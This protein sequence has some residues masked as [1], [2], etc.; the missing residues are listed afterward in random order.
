MLGRIFAGVRRLFSNSASSYPVSDDLLFALLG[1]RQNNT[2]SGVY[3]NPESALTYPPV[4]QAVD[5]LSTAVAKTSLHLNRVLPQGGKQREVKHWA[6]KLVSRKPSFDLTAF[7][8]KRCMVISALQNGNAYSYIRREGAAVVELVPL[9]STRVRPTREYGKGLQYVVK[10]KQPDGSDKEQTYSPADIFHIRDL[11]Y[12]DGSCGRSRVKVC[13]EAIAHGIAMQLFGGK[14]FGSGLHPSGL[15]S[16]E[17]KVPNIEEFRQS[18]EQ[19]HAGMTNAH[20]LMILDQ[21]AKF[22]P[23]STNPE[24][25]QFIE[26]QKF[27]RS[28]VGSIFN[29]P[30]SRLNDTA[31]RTWASLDQDDLFFLQNSLEPWFVSFETEAWDKLLTEQDKDNGVLSFEFNRA[32][33]LKTD[34]RTQYETLYRAT[35]GPVL[36]P[37]EGRT[38]LNLPAVE[39]GDTLRVPS[40]TEPINKPPEEPQNNDV[41]PA[42]KQTV[43]RYMAES[44]H[45]EVAA[46][47]KLTGKPKGFCDGVADYYGQF[48]K[49]LLAA[50]TPAVEGYEAVSHGFL[51]LI[52]AVRDYVAE[53]QRRIGAIADSASY[54]ELAAAVEQETTDWP[55]RAEQFVN[56]LFRE[57]VLAKAA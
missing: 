43:A 49:H 37:N 57:S 30:A 16:V 56:E 39:G 40:N 24:Q 22:T 3:V 27:V 12:Y 13:K 2:Q 33:V 10:V 36:T 26:T 28:I 55:D 11:P 14:F 38:W 52:P 41:L 8:W 1:V 9:D 44:V 31:T 29:I 51:P 54:A 6:D 50:L 48:E 5:L 20:R 7:L 53:S 15:L 46:V 23:F 45:R 25:S 47:Q 19:H 4:L 17:G 21:N 35:G 32:E 42:A 34:P 18:Y